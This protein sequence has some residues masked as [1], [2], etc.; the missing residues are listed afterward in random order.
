M[1]LTSIYQQTPDINIARKVYVESFL[2][3]TCLTLKESANVERYLRIVYRK[4]PGKA[5]PSNWL[6]GM[7]RWMGS[8]FHDSTDYNGS[9][10]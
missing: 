6:L 9:P 2:A 5:L 7:C 10:F 1:E 8:H 3:T 4:L